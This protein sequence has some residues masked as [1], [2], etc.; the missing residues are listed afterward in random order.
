MIAALISAAAAILIASLTSYLNKQKERDSEWRSKKLAYYEEFFAAASGIVGE[1]EVAA[2][3]VRFANSVNQLHLFAAQ[4]VI[5]SLHRYLAETESSNKHR[6]SGMQEVL[7]S[8]LVWQIRLDLR[9]KPTNSL[10]TFVAVS[11]ASGTGANVPLP[12][13]NPFA[14]MA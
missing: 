2:A 4:S 13:A 10:S 9:I 7:W 8:N 5:D 3:K 6:T 1:V 11:W 12:S 14:R